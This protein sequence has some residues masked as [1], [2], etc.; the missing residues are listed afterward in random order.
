MFQ[1]VRLLFVRR[2]FDH[3]RTSF[4]ARVACILQIQFPWFPCRRNITSGLS[5][6]SPRKS[7]RATMCVFNSCYNR[8]RGKWV[9]PTEPDV[10]I[11]NL[12]QII[13]VLRV[14]AYVRNMRTNVDAHPIKVA[15]ISNGKARAIP[16]RYRMG[17]CRGKGS[18]EQL[19]GLRDT[20]NTSRL[21]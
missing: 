13:S 2:L 9:C 20:I 7:L 16:L 8:G 5:L 12:R 19:R 10:R 18:R 3:I 15:I 11:V 1:N 14:K 4:S 6:I 21:S 17:T